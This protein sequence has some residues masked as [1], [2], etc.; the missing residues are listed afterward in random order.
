M[1]SAKPG[2]RILIN[3]ISILFL[4]VATL[5][6]FLCLVAFVIIRIDTPEYILIPLT[7]VILTFSSFLDSFLLA[8]VLKENGIAIG[9]LTGIFFAV[10]IIAI[11][12]YYNTFCISNILITK[13]LAVV[14]AGA[15]GGIIGVNT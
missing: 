4:T 6:F 9:I 12:L 13:I 5:G 11:A 10:F 1:I 15:V 7:T 14:L 2:Q 3:F 8:K